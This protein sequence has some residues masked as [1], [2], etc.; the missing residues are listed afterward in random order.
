M[1]L[2]GFL[3]SKLRNSYIDEPGLTY[4][5]RR[6]VMFAGVVELAN[7]VSDGSRPAA[8]HFFLRRYRHIPFYME[9]VENPELARYMRRIGWI[10]V[11]D[12]GA[13]DIG[14]PCFIS[15]LM[16]HLHKDTERY[17]RRYPQITSRAEKP[18]DNESKQKRQAGTS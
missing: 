6:S 17:R 11:Y 1:N 16:H 14:L 5:V 15:P 13:E 18:A 2:E 12:P 4:Y 7:V 9:N 10:E 8:L 3:A